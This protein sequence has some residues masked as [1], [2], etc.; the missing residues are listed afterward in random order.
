MQ[1]AINRELQNSIEP[2]IAEPYSEEGQAAIN[3]ADAH[4]L[5]VWEDGEVTSTKSHNGDLYRARRLHQVQRPWLPRSEVLFEVPED[6]DDHKRMVI[7]DKQALAEMAEYM[8]A[9]DLGPNELT[10]HLPDEE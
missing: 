7:T 4:I 3:E 6:D 9:H 5:E 1:E 10:H 8:E 2:Y